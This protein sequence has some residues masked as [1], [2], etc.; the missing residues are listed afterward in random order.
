[1]PKAIPIS[2]SESSTP[3]WATLLAAA[4]QQLQLLLSGEVDEVEITGANG[5]TQRYKR[6]DVNKVMALID[7]LEKKANRESGTRT[8]ALAVIRRF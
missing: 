7:A 1:M 6:R 8:V 5:G 2:G 3:T 4:K